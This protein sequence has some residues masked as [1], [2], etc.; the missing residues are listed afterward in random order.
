MTLPDRPVRTPEPDGPA[1]ASALRTLAAE[2]DG[3]AALIEAIRTDLGPAFEAAVR[4]MA[5][6]TGRVIVT[7]M[8]KSGHIGRKIAATLSSTGTPAYFVHPGEASH[9]DLGVIQRD[10]IILALSWSGETSELSDLI[11]YAKRF[12]VAVVA[13]TARA[14]STLG[15]E[16]D[17]CLALP[18]AREAC[19]NGL[20]PTT[21][22]TMQL[23]L[24]DALAVALLETRGF[25]AQDFRDVHPGGKLGALL[26]QVRSV[27]HSGERMPVV[28]LG[29]AMSEAIVVQSEKGFGCVVVVDA[30]GA[31]AGIVTDGDL[32]RHMGGDLLARTVDAV[33]TARPLTI[34][35]DTLLVEA[36]EMVESRK[37]T[38]LI[39][40]EAGRPVGIVHVLDLLRAGAA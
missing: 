18:S 23:V 38:A 36:L 17:L 16:A 1:I 40:A 15:R 31:V 27:M 20:A 13:I 2:R 24:G 25:S 35:P 3:V 26:R 11:S 29:T 33:M 32:R 21:S 37:I 30:D 12:R 19:P 22:T 4:R 8:G 14:D 39:V 9:G 5:E 6:T 34:P 7:G 10:D 28:P